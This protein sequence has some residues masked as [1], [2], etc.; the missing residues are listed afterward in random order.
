MENRNRDAA[1]NAVPQT[2][3]QPADTNEPIEGA[4]THQNDELRR[5]VAAGMSPEDAEAE[6]FFDA[7]H[8]APISPDPKEDDD[9]DEEE[10]KSDWGHTDPTDSPFPDS[11]DP[12]GPGSAV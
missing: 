1:H 6:R 10:A 9:E 11:N 4:L 12:S 5:A 2:D 8:H 3:W 7:N